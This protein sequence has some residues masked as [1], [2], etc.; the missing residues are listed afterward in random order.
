MTGDEAG[1]IAEAYG[2]GL[3]TRPPV[4]M[5]RGELGRIW[6]L[7]TERGSWAVK[8]LLVPTD[9]ATARAD[10]EFQ[11]AALEA[12]LPL[13]HP[14][15]RPDGAVLTALER[16]DGSSVGYRV[17][18]WV[19]L[20]KPDRPPAPAIAAVLLARLHGL[21]RAAHGPMHPWFSEPLGPEG[22][23]RLV[24]DVRA[25]APPW[26]EALERLAPDA[27]AAEAVIAQAGLDH[28][29]T[30]ALRR[31][32]L[33]FNPENVLVD[34]AGRAVILD[35]ENSESAPLEQELT[36]AVLD[37]APEPAAARAFLD[38]YHE[39]GGPAEIRDR[40]SFALAVAVQSHLADT[41]ARRGITATTD[42]G[43]AHAAYR[44]DELDRTLFTLASIDRL[45]LELGRG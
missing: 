42:E 41:Y 6:R 30:A 20:M 15:V 27:L 8:E 18:T 26:L 9:E 19:D 44:I 35:W 32:H 16:A 38:A 13:P 34:A 29:P 21:D 11:A 31:C 5:A 12:G 24:D 39:A 3:P 14:I 28:L 1:H 43:R 33:D 4:A 37:F 2:L 17:Y 36:Y 7:D 22:W 10:L 45:L 40:S 25:A 23:A